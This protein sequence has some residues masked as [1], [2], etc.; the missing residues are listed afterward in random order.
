MTLLLREVGRFL[1]G[2]TAWV[3]LEF[4][5]AA[6]IATP[7]VLALRLDRTRA[8]GTSF[9]GAVAVAALAVRFAAPLAWA[10]VIGGRPLPVVWSIAGALI[11]TAL[12]A[13]ARPKTPVDP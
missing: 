13:A 2:A 7:G 9:L 8:V 6:A 10:P 5:I 4:T 3:G 11:A 12:T 1:L